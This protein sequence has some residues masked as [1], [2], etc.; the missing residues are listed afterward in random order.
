MSDSIVLSWSGGKDSALALREVLRG[1]RRV[2]SLL[3]TVTEGDDRIGMHRVRLALLERQAAALN[4]PLRVVRVPRNPSNVEYEARVLGAL[5]EFQAQGVT[6][7][8]FGDLFLADI[9]AYRDQMLARIGMKTEYPLWERDTGALAREFI[10]AG[11]KAVLVCVDER[12]LEARFAGRWFNEALLRD[13]PSGVDPCGERGEFHTF[14]CDGP[15]FS[16]PITFRKAAR[17]TDGP[18][19]FCDLEPV[20]QGSDR[21]VTKHCPC[22]GAAFPCGPAAGQDHCWC[23]DLPHVGP[24]AGAE[25]NCLCPACLRTAVGLA[26]K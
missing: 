9:R 25:K 3:T 18:F 12:Q 2:V 1:G 7:A 6:T 8:V 24:V 19:H 16:R 17:T 15:A 23:F 4:L 14:V 5:K 10:D 13:L 21:S 11:F 22:C 20:E 26:P